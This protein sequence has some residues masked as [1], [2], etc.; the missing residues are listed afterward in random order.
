MLE[1]ETGYVVPGGDVGPLADRL[2]TLLTDAG[3]RRRMGERGRA[4]VSEEW[5]WD[6]TAARL[7]T[8]LDPA[9][10]VTDT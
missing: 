4:W 9:E 1:G 2:V 8:L 6:T 7:A 3:L 10:P 5:R